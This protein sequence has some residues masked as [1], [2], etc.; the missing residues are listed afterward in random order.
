MYAQT[1]A[2]WRPSACELQLAHTA[3]RFRLTVMQPVQATV[4]QIKVCRAATGR[5]DNFWLE[6]PEN[7]LCRAGL[8][9]IQ[10]TCTAESCRRQEHAGAQSP[11]SSSALACS[12]HS[13]LHMPAG[14]QEGEEI[15]FAVLR[16]TL[17]IPGFDE[18]QLP[19]VVAGLCIALL[20]ANRQ[21]SA[22]EVSQAQVILLRVCILQ[23]QNTS[24]CYCPCRGSS[25]RCSRQCI[26]RVHLLQIGAAHTY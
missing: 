6:W 11:A 4:R 19:R 24:C 14:E 8:G 12:C 7:L 22:A 23:L 1:E 25:N 26:I 2:S 9:K 13:E 10:Q 3:A 5:D 16:M 20:L 18:K 17:G 21:F 15:D